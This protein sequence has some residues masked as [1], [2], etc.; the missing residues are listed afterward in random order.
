MP[1]VVNE[2]VRIHY[3]VVGQ[4]PTLLLHTG[5]GGDSRMWRDAGYVQGLP[6][7]RLVLMDQRGRGQSS[8]PDRL[9]D[10]RMECFVSDV[11]AVL[12]DVGV[13]SVG[14]WG[15]S[16]GAVVGI[17]F[18]AEHPTRLRSLVCTGSLP[19]LDLTELPPV[20]DVPK[21]IERLVAQAGVVHELEMFMDRTG[22]RFP[23]PI[24]RNVREGDP[25]MYALDGVA[26]MSWR[27]P[28]SA[29]PTFPAPVLAIGGEREDSK[30]QT[31]QSIERLPDGRVVR[32][33]GLGHLGA[34]Y[35]SDLALPHARPFLERTLKES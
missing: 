14:F 35:R 12:D 30:R 33:A 22:E 28:K 29:Y 27:G 25:R 3:E 11:N 10:H 5:A 9:E 31:E 20:A 21:E 17:A 8:R 13:D 18:G 24:D 2:S 26:W 34:F 1:F 19:F 23:D 16:N 4:G 15:Y 7:F 32:L 6:G